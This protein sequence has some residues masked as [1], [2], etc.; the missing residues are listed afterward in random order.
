[1]SNF[2]SK[3]D[4]LFSTIL[5]SFSA[6]LAELIGIFQLFG[7]FIIPFDFAKTTV[8]NTI[9]STGSLAFLAAIMLPLT[10][11]LLIVSKKWWKLLSI[12][13]IIVSAL[14]LF[15]VNYP[16]VWWAV[17]VGS[18]LIMVF[19]IMKRDIFDGRWMALPMFFLAVSLFFCAFKP[20]N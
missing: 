7:W 20:P 15:L 12:L 19:V 18:A 14:V 16:I 9:G 8:F 6:L 17:I 3:K 2:F 4:I 11:L 1:V 13:E 10:I 5:L